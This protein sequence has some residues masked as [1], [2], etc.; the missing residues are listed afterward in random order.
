MRSGGDCIAAGVC[1]GETILPLPG[2]GETDAL[3][4]K[5]GFKRGILDGV[6]SFTVLCSKGVLWTAFAR[7]ESW[8]DR[9]S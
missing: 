8:A 6:E 3:H 7:G 5:T 1:V 2:R 4:S 9:E